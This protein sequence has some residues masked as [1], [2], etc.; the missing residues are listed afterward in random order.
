MSKA[1]IVTATVL[2]TG[3][4][5]AVTVQADEAEQL[6]NFYCAQCHGVGGKGDGPNVTADFPVDPRNFTKADEMEKLS[7]ADIKNVILEGGPVVSKSP[8]MPPWGKTLSDEQVDALVQY[9]RKLC[10]CVGKPG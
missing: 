5:S 2:L 3:F 9:L 7:D 6:F 1:T 10:N 8:M 4:L